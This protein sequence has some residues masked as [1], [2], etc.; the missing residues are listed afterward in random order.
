MG[1]GSFKALG[2]AYAVACLK[3]QKGPDAD[4]LV[5]CASAGNHGLSV[6]A[7][8]RHFGGQAVIVL[9]ESV[10]SDFENRLLA[11][12]A[13]V[14]RSGATYEESMEAAER[15]ARDRGG[16]L[17]ADSSWE[18][19]REIPWLVMEGYTVISHELAAQFGDLGE[20]PDEVFLQAGV[21]GL[22]GALTAHIRRTWD[23]QPRIWVVEP[24][25]AACLKA[26]MEL[27]RPARVEGPSS[28]MG[29]L[30]C[31]EA[32]H[33]AFEILSEGADRFVTVTDQEAEEV[34]HSFGST[35]S[36]AAGLAGALEAQLSSKARVLCLLTESA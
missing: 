5:V 12:K 17:L 14:I 19:Y 11:Q 23:A 30:D 6:A 3:E 33:L 16:V 36:A 27:G 9:S 18:G 22:A 20:W 35:S 7:G 4:L 29:R 10:P 1:L 26:S 8:A 13:E 28:S 15:L 34:A 21:G 25:S 32:S 31:K 2:G 24:Q